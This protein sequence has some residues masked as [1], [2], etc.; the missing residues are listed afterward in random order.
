MF[1]K[2]LQGRDFRERAYQCRPSIM[3]IIVLVNARTDETSNLK[4]WQNE[5]VDDLQRLA[6]ALAYSKP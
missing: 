5:V 2:P 3:L 1:P 4:D 6:L